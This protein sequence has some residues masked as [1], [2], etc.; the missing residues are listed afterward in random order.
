M[1]DEE[2]PRIFNNDN[3]TD[4]IE[5]FA[6]SLSEEFDSVVIVCRTSEGGYSGD[7]VTRRGSSI[8]NYGSLKIAAKRL[9]KF[10][11]SPGETDLN[12]EKK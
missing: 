10:L 8:T 5:A 11:L 2:L 7:Y 3:V 1:S 6:N 12:N 4:R 9:E